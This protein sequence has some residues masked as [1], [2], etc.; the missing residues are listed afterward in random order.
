MSEL[1][2]APSRAHRGVKIALAIGAG[3]VMLTSVVGLA[4]I[5]ALDIG[6]STGTLTRVDISPTLNCSVTHAGDTHNEF[7]TDGADPDQIGACG[8]F[9]TDGT[10]VFGPTSIAAGDDLTN[11]AAYVA[12]TPVSQTERTGS[13][14]AADPFKVVTVVRGGPFTVTE[15]DTYQSDVE[16]YRTDVQVTSSAAVDAVVYRAADCYLQD[17]D[18]GLG[19]LLAGGAPTCGAGP[20]S[21]NPARILERYPLT[22]GSHHI[23]GRFNDT[24]IALSA[25]AALPDTVLHDDQENGSADEGFTYDN[26]AA[27]SWNVHLD[28]GAS[29][30]FSDLTVFSPAGVQPLTISSTASNQSPHPGDRFT[31][32]VRISNPSGVPVSIGSIIDTLP[33]GLR[34]VPG[35]TKGVTTADPAVSGQ[36]LTW[37]G[38]YRIPAADG[39]TPGAFDLSF[40]VEV[41]GTPGTYTNRVTIVSVD[42]AAI[43]PFEDANPVIVVA[44]APAPPSD[45]PAAAAQPVTVADSQL[46]SGIAVTAS[47][48]TSSSPVGAP[49]TFTG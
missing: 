45:P 15:T 16:A 11:S 8:T 31:Y 4:P 6:S 26:S 33:S 7:F 48:P 10:N 44:A 28:A 27:L 25:L 47:G 24:W 46:E 2:S 1:F 39:T 38:P 21:Q 41:V 20:M 12:W 3:L 35:S 13:G 5:D 43:L 49:M 22:P 40:D 14:S 36:D 34:F 9:V 19:A 29:A 18:F 37:S 17:D 32:T 23:V 42:G 30:T